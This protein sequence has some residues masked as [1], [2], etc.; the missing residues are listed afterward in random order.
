MNPR[1]QVPR[2]FSGRSVTL[3]TPFRLLYFETFE[4]S[5]AVS[6]FDS[7]YDRYLRGEYRLTEQEELG[8]TLFFSQQFTNCNRCHLLE[9]SPM[10]PHETFTGYGYHNIG[11]PANS[12]VRAENGVGAD[13]VDRGLLEN[14]SVTGADQS[15]KYKVPTL[16]NAAVTGPYMHNGVFRD[17]E[18]VVRCYNRY[19]RK[20]A[21][22]QINPETGQPWGDPE[23]AENLS[24]ADLEHGPALDKKRIQ[25]LVAFLN[26]LT[27]KRFE[28]LLEPRTASR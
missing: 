5:E 27:Y 2:P 16:R 21:R 26:M 24:L 22:N 10:A 4:R 25:A 12:A 23:V 9:T 20:S 19:N 6:P 13:H 8:R 18:T 17:L 14:P 28:P 7:K 11:V 1:P 15:G 3:D